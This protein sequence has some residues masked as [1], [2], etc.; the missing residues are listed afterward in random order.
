MTLLNDFFYIRELQCETGQ[1]RALLK[2][3]ADHQILTG[4][5]PG[6]PVMPGVC[7]MQIA[8]EVFEEATRMSVRIIKGDNMKFLAVLNPVVHGEVKLIITHEA[9]ADEYV[10]TANL[11]SI[12]AGPD[13]RTRPQRG[14]TCR[15]HRP[16]SRWYVVSRTWWA[17]Q[18]E[19]NDN[20]R[21]RHC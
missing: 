15:C 9:V 8:R 21:T 7:M 6:F 13:S 16:C 11:S 20:F 19:G 4:H 18:S 14:R 2:I 12:Q 17:R 10:I 3:N 5:F 1:I